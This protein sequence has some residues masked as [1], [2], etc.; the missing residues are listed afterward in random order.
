MID[1][2]RSRTLIGGLAYSLRGD[3]EGRTLCAVFVA[4]DEFAAIVDATPEGERF[5]D[6]ILWTRGVHNI[7]VLGVPV[8]RYS[9]LA[10]AFESEPRP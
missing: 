5:I 9:D 8:A 3:G 10:R 6:D 1:G 7:A 2:S 4:D